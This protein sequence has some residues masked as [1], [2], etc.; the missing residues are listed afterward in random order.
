MRGEQRATTY[1]ACSRIDW[2]SPQSRTSW[3]RPRRRAC[4]PASL[5][6]TS[7]SS[8]VERVAVVAA[9]VLSSPMPSSPKARPIRASS[10]PRSSAPCSCPKYVTRNSTARAARW[11]TVSRTVCSIFTPSHLHRR[12]ASQPVAPVVRLDGLCPD[13]RLAP[14]LAVSH[15]LQLLNLRHLSSQAARGWSSRTLQ[16]PPL[17]IAMASRC[18]SRPCLGARRHPSQR[19]RIRSHIARLTFIVASRHRS[20]HQRPTPQLPPAPGRAP[21]CAGRR[22]WAGRNAGARSPRAR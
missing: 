6:A 9:P 13:L 4:R 12:E 20:L 21:A 16:C 8:G 3:R 19:R 10:S 5:R 18:P 1:C 14:Y 11:R 2:Y 17:K 15:S 7:R 22:D